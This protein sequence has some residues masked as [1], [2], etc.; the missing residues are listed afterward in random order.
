MGERQNG[1][2][3]GPPTAVLQPKLPSLG[4]EN[5]P[6]EIS[7]HG[8]PHPALHAINQY[9]T[10]RRFRRMMCRP[11]MKRK[12]VTPAGGSWAKKGK[13]RVT[14]NMSASLPHPGTHLHLVN[15][16]E[17]PFCSTTTK[18]NSTTEVYHCTK[19]ARLVTN[20]RHKEAKPVL[21]APSYHT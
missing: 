18:T 9:N 17:T 2:K 20:R 1:T 5:K 11:H 21:C 6:F 4:R 16:K 12:M 13:Q 14:P 7:T 15:V 3:K 8:T 19:L 10:V